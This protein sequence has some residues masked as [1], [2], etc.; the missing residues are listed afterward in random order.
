VTKDVRAAIDAERAAKDRLPPDSRG[1]IVIMS[2]IG[3]G[4]MNSAVIAIEEA[5]GRLSEALAA[6]APSGSPGPAAVPSD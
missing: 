5:R 3:R 2:E 4:G 6:A 1:L